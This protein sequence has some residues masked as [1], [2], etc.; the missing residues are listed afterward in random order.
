M[1]SNN[2]CHHT[3]QNARNRFR[4]AF[5]RG[6]LFFSI[7]CRIKN[8]GYLRH[9]QIRNQFRIKP[10]LR[11]SNKESCTANPMRFGTSDYR[12]PK[13]SSPACTVIMNP[14][15]FKR[16]FPFKLVMHVVDFNLCQEPPFLKR[17]HKPKV[18]YSP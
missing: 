18:P 7:G 13:I 10:N 2:P 5:A 17:F 14:V 9:H 12:F 6:L 15:C 16:F 4:P 8:F 1:Q 11:Q 3:W